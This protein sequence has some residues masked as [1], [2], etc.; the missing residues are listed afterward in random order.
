VPATGVYSCQL[1]RERPRIARPRARQESGAVDTCCSTEVAQPSGTAGA[2]WAGGTL[3]GRSLFHS[4]S[5]V[6]SF[7]SSIRYIQLTY[8]RQYRQRANRTESDSNR[9]QVGSSYVESRQ[10]SFLGGRIN[11]ANRYGTPIGGR[12]F[13][14]SE[15]RTAPLQYANRS[16][17]QPPP[18]PAA[19][20]QSPPHTVASSAPSSTRRA[21]PHD[22]HGEMASLQE[23]PRASARPNRQYPFPSRTACTQAARLRYSSRCARAISRSSVRTCAAPWRPLSRIS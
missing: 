3:D 18:P 15:Y 5:F 12:Y 8:P 1:L 4:R 23:P 22:G 7:M 9:F 20:H 17:S 16:R 11:I 19:S 21:R 2:R 6:F 13:L 10:C 14:F